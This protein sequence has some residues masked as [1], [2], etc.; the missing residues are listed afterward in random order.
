MEQNMVNQ[1]AN[2]IGKKQQEGK[3]WKKE[4]TPWIVAILVVGGF[5]FAF[6]WRWRSD[7]RN[8]PEEKLEAFLE[9]CLMQDVEL[10]MDHVSYFTQYLS[11]E[12][13]PY[14]GQATLKDGSCLM[15]TAQWERDM[16][17]D[18]G[19]YTDY[20]DE[21]AEHYM[22]KHGMIY[23]IT[24]TWVEVDVTEAQL[25]GE[26][27]ILKECLTDIWESDY[28]QSGQEMILYLNSDLGLSYHLEMNWESL[29]YEEIEKQLTSFKEN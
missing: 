23:H 3:N 20:G 4:L 5:V 21:L 25:T 12:Y 16:S 10:Q 13:I 2:S 1:E 6:V 7:I 8:Y 24:D 26:N 9:D 22:E 18:Y 28:I 27:P 15:F 19:V 29:P 17:L 14:V 11:S